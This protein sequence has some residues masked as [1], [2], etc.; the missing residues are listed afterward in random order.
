MVTPRNS[1]FLLFTLKQ[2]KYTTSTD[3]PNF[4]FFIYTYDQNSGCKKKPCFNFTNYP[5]QTRFEL[6]ELVYSV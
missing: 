4:N 6:N 3:V 2:K 5:T 1:F